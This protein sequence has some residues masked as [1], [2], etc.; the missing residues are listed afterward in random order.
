MFKKKETE[1]DESNT[2]IRIDNEFDS[3]TNL[4]TLSTSSHSSLNNVEEQATSISSEA[5]RYANLISYPPIIITGVPAFTSHSSLAIVQFLR[6]LVNA[7]PTLPRISDTSWRLNNKNQL[8][9]CAPTRDVY[10]LLLTNNYPSTI[11]TST[12]QVIPLRRLPAQLSPLLL[13]VPGYLDDSYF[14]EEIQKHFRSVKYLHRIRTFSNTNNSTLVCIDFENAQECDQCLQAQYLSVANV[15]LVIKQYLGPPRIPQCTKCCSFVHF[16]NHCSST[17]KICNKC[18]TS[19]L[20]DTNHQCS[21]IRCINCSKLANHPFDINHDAFDHHCPSMLNFKKML[22]TKLVEQGIVSNHIYVP[23]ELQHHLRQVRERLPPVTPISSRPILSTAARHATGN[24]TNTMAPKLTS[25]TVIVPQSSRSISNFI[26]FMQ[27]TVK[28]FEDQLSNLAKQMTNLTVLF[29]IQ[30]YKIDYIRKAKS[31]D[32]IARQLT[33]FIDNASSS[34]IEMN[35]NSH[36]N[37]MVSSQSTAHDAESWSST[38]QSRAPAP[39]VVDLSSINTVN[40][41]ANML[42]KRE[43]IE[44]EQE[45]LQ[46]EEEEVKQEIEKY[47][48]SGQIDVSSPEGNRLPDIAGSKEKSTII[49]DRKGLISMDITKSINEFIIILGPAPMLNDNYVV[50][51]EVI[52]GMAIFDSINACVDTVNGG[53]QPFDAI[54]IYSCS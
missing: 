6:S 13:N 31:I 21:S 15:R 41:L 14:L 19:I 34:S 18:A 35:D 51:G 36:Q 7:H 10:S 2:K 26:D 39:F 3:H 27:T 32:D 30:E 24:T 17:H 5:L 53:G 49:H 44:R 4:S 43:Q 48:S 50:F 1:S 11:G 28:P 47:L 37:I 46:H 23:K 29:I 22:V 8:L 12:I 45:R 40:P 38:S 20:I 33:S 25:T 52:S 54:S 16:A 9:L 42:E